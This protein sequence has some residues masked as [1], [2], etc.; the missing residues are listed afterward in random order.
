MEYTFGVDAAGPAVASRSRPTSTP[1]AG[2]TGTPSRRAARRA[3]R[4]AATP[5]TVGPLTARPVAGHLPGMP[6]SRFWEFEDA[7]VD[8]G[9]VEAEPEDIGRMLL[10]E[11]ALVF[12]GDWLLVPLEVPLGS[13][14][15]IVSL[16]VRDTFGRTLRVGPTS[17]L[18]GALGGWRM[19]TLSGDAGVDPAVP[20]AIALLVAPVLAARP[21][22]TRSRGGAAPAR[23]DRQ[24]RLGGR[25]ADRGAATASPST[26]PRSPTP[27]GRRRTGRPR[28]S[29][30]RDLRLP[31]GHARCPSTGCRC[32]PQRAASRGPV[33]RAAPGRT[34]ARPCPTARPATSDLSAGCFSRRP[35]AIPSCARRRSRAQGARVTRAYQLAR[36]MD[37]STFLW[38]GRRK[39]V[40]R[41]EGSS[42]LRYDVM[43]GGTAG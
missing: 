34:A 7:V 28:P 35:A 41:G 19:F 29:R 22:G 43:D 15:R 36:W 21:A 12:G 38:L 33:D 20:V 10:T 25:A 30:P 11:F 42:G 6:A 3:T 17:A 2:S 4:P 5:T 40:G 18:E 24:P 23:R 39:V 13:L 1:T 26:G 16:D 32:C 14:V 31:A 8:F 27:G 9:G 37:G